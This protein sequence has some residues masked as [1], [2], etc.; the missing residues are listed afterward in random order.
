[1]FQRFKRKSFFIKVANGEMKKFM[2]V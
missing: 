1:M 2:N